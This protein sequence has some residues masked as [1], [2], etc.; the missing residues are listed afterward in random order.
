M[1]KQTFEPGCY[2]HVFNRGNNKEK[3]FLEEENYRYF[4]RLMTKYLGL[5]FEIHAYCLMSNHFHWLIRVKE[6]EEMLPQF[7]SGLKGVHQPISNMFNAYAKAI[8][9]RYGRTG[10][11]FQEHIHRIKI[12]NEQYFRQ[13]LIYIH[14]NPYHHG[15]V[16]DFT[17]YEF[18]SYKAYITSKNSQVR[19]DFALELF[20]GIDNL[21]FEHNQIII[22]NNVILS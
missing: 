3:L 12:E 10:S 8:N 21:C 15:F 14:K 11:L 16:S 20:G 17:K 1:R 7:Q 13:V 22:Q 6:L 5:V 19:R 2:Y 4:L 9:K 18:S